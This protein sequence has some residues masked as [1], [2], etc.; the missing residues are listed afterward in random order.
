[1]INYLIF[2]VFVDFYHFYYNL[3][4]FSLSFCAGQIDY[5]FQYHLHFIS[6]VGY[7]CIYDKLQQFHLLSVPAELQISSIISSHCH[8]ITSVAQCTF[9]RG[10]LSLF[11]FLF[12]L[13]RQR[14][15][16]YSFESHF[17]AQLPNFRPICPVFTNYFQ[18][19][20]I[21]IY[22]VLMFLKF[23]KSYQESG[24]I[25]TQFWDKRKYVRKGWMPICKLDHRASSYPSQWQP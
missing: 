5:F 18:T 20:R 4:N 13:S 24:I 11:L 2:S 25:F 21:Y 9:G 15:N 14:C 23:S 12:Y 6:S 7:N 8:F 1:M 3:H 17:L 22:T 19:Q 16:F 10:A